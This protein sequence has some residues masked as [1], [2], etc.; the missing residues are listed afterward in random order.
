MYSW[1]CVCSDAIARQRW[2]EGDPSRQ[3]ASRSRSGSGGIWGG[4]LSHITHCWGRPRPRS[5]STPRSG[6]ALPA[7]WPRHRPPSRN[8]PDLLPGAPAWTPADTRPM[9]A[10]G[11][12]GQPPISVLDGPGLPRAAVCSGHAGTL[13]SGQRARRARGPVCT[14]HY[15]GFASALSNRPAWK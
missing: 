13:S 2:F 10:R 1:V 3:P 8:R 15:R 4:S 6:R 12:R 5:R 11:I 14:R 7:F 9:S